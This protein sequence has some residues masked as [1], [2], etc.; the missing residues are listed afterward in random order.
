MREVNKVNAM[1]TD[2]QE[3]G[4]EISPNVTKLQGAG[5]K[6]YHQ[7]NSEGQTSSAYTL[8]LSFSPVVGRVMAD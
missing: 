1:N 3:R 6:K 2:M 8:D 4:E 5:R 7:H